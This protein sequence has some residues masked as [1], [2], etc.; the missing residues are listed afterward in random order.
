ML[1]GII[2][3]IILFIVD[4][5]L[6]YISPYL[7]KKKENAL[8]EKYRKSLI[9][10]KG[11]NAI[12]KFYTYPQKILVSVEGISANIRINYIDIKDECNI[13][14]LIL[15]DVK[16]I[17][18]FNIRANK[19]TFVNSN[20]REQDGVIFDRDNSVCFIYKT[21]TINNLKNLARNYNIKRS[22]LKYFS[23]AS[24]IQFIN[25]G[26]LRI[27]HPYDE[28]EG[29]P[30]LVC[31]KIIDG[32]SVKAIEINYHNLNYLFINDEIKQVTYE[33][34]C[35][36]ERIDLDKSRYL[37]VRDGRLV[38]R[39][40]NLIISNFNYVRKIDKNSPKYYYKPHYTIKKNI[41]F[42]RKEEE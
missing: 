16:Q 25:K 13:N 24:Y 9:E 26:V 15:D 1:L 29:V 34:D 8:E 32:I 31:P 4:I 39:K 11:E 5:F 23:N 7:E 28:E 38:Y 19:I 12:L 10:E 3:I 27:S 2:V 41:T 22:A 21:Q 18:N 40:Y 17:L 42:C 30:K 33:V 35:N 37:K 6:I 20:Y 36:I 14:E